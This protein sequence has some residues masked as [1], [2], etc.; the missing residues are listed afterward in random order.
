MYA[1]YER[2]M[3]D[4]SLHYKFIERISLFGCNEGYIPWLLEHSLEAGQS[5]PLKWH[6]NLD[7]ALDKE[8]MK[9]R[10]LII[11]LKPNNTNKTLSLYEIADVWGH[12]SSDWTPIMFHLRG[13][14]VDYGLEGLDERNFSRSVEEIDDPIFSMLYLK[15]SVRDGKIVGKWTAPRASPTNSAL[16]WPDTFEFFA[17]EARKFF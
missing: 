3:T 4:S 13:L 2:S 11:D 1:A 15:G 12:S 6:V 9:N 7:E 5:E 14:F 16:L 10:A 17:N 8:G